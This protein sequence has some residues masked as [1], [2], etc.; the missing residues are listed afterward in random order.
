M[1]HDEIIS[2]LSKNPVDIIKRSKIRKN[3]IV[4]GARTIEQDD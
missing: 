1:T 2:S 3:V 4:Q